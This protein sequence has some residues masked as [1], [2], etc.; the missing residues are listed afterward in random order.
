MGISLAVLR[1][2]AQIGRWP[3]AVVG[4]ISRAVTDR[5]VWDALCASEM[6]C[7]RL[8]W[9]DFA[10]G[11]ESTSEEVRSLAKFREREQNGQ[12]GSLIAGRCALVTPSLAKV[13][14]AA[15]IGQR[16]GQSPLSLAQLFAPPRALIQLPLECCEELNQ[17]FNLFPSGDGLYVVDY[18]CLPFKEQSSVF[19]VA[20]GPEVFVGVDN[21]ANSIA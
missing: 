12:W 3:D 21:V 18:L 17:V 15:Q 11:A 9:L 8:Y 4:R 7:P 5:P 19:S 6:S 20:A 13:R 2:I 16:G 14:E 1:A 10:R